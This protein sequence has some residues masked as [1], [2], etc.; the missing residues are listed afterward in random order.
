MMTAMKVIA[1][2]LVFLLFAIWI[3]AGII[4]TVAQGSAWLLLTGVAAFI[5]AFTRY[6]CRETS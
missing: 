4:Q 5:F 2:M 1:A 6:G 3:G